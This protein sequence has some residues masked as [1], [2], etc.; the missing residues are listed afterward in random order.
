MIQDQSKELTLIVYNSPKPPRYLKL[1][2]KLIR[3]LSVVIPLLTIFLL[4]IAFLYSMF[5]KNKLND[6]RAKE[7]KVIQDL[8]KTKKTFKRQFK[9]YPLKIKT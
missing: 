6:L 8:R 7:P 2:K 9:L 1:N 3:T 5:L 4:S